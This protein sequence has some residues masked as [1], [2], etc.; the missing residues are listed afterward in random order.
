[1]T[2]AEVMSS[3]QYADASNLT[4]RQQLHERFSTNPYGWH[5]WVFDQLDV[6]EDCCLLE[7][8][9]GPAVLWRE[10]AARIPAGWRITLSDFSP[11]MLHEARRNL[12]ACRHPFSLQL[13]DAQ[14]IPMAGE[15]VDVIV[16][17]HMLYHV[18][19]I[20]RALA[21]IHRV[22]K[23]GGRLY[24]AANGRQHLR[25]LRG[26]LGRCMGNVSDASKGAERF[27]LENGPEL[28]APW[29]T[30]VAVRRYE[31]AL[32]VTQVGPLV[33]YVV[34]EARIWPFAVEDKQAE[35]TRQLD[36]ELSRNGAIRV[37]KDSGLIVA[38]KRNP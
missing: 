9:C 18:P 16:A 8:G 36:R 23:P 21:E 29:F 37:A 1:M 5:R 19:D 34:S 13:A 12:S 22:L 30:E 27:G 2:S 6:A 25:E 24:A 33:A 15:S 38:R 10:N 14:A 20:P 11:G 7:L 32:V 17:N 31:D 35:Y 4:V 3:E 28:L 26:L